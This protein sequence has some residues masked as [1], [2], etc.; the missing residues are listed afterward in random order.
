[1]P[2]FFFFFS[3]H[4]LNYYIFLSNDKWWLLVKFAVEAKKSRG[5][6]LELLLLICY[7]CYGLNYLSLS[8][9]LSLHGFLGSQCHRFGGICADLEV[10][11]WICWIVKFRKFFHFAMEQTLKMKMIFLQHF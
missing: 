10:C 11:A 3:S 1:M 9:S 5:H 8:L 4:K 6:W 2:F 7:R